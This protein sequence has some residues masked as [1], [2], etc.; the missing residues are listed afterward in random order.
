M[1]NELRTMIERQKVR[2]QKSAIIKKQLLEFLSCINN[3]HEKPNV[4]I[5]CAYGQS[6]SQ[7]SS[8]H[9]C[10]TIHLSCTHTT[11]VGAFFSQ[12]L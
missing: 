3:K 8:F 9:T 10:C 7:S 6:V 4:L 12:L 2:E 1:P 5:M 11:A